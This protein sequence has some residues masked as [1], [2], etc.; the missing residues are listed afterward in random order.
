MA[1]AGGVDL[2]E[3]RRLK[4]AF[5]FGVLN[6]RDASF[7]PFV[8]VG[9]ARDGGVFIVPVNIGGASWTH[10]PLDTTRSVQDQPAL[11]TTSERPKLHYHRSGIVRA[12]LDGA[13]IDTGTSRFEPL[14]SRAANTFLTATVVKVADLPTKEVRRGDVSTIEGGWPGLVT[15]SFAVIHLSDR[16][17]AIG[18]DGE[19]NPLGLTSE[20]PAQFIIDLA[21]Y[22]QSVQLLAQISTNLESPPGLECSICVAAYPDAGTIAGQVP[23]MSHALWNANARNPLLGLPE[24]FLWEAERQSRAY[25]DSY[26]RRFNRLPPWHKLSRTW[27]EPPFVL[28]VRG[29]QSL[30]HLF[31]KLRRDPRHTG[32]Y[33]FHPDADFL[34]RTD[35]SQSSAVNPPA[36]D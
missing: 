19:L 8:N 9:L 28:A 29:L 23:R 16:Q 36:D 5:R 32:R 4:R 34:E 26:V 7:K 27:W 20:T 17:R 24:D 2:S 3:A 12:T 14:H 6:A 13:R 30:R 22:G 21:G 31:G 33:I 18:D 10:G 11:S 1:E 25:R 15:L 35:S